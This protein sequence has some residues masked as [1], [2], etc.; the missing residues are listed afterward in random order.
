MSAGIPASPVRD[1]ELLPVVGPDMAN[2]VAGA[3]FEPA[4]MCTPEAARESRTASGVRAQAWRER[5]VPLLLGAAAL[6]TALALTGGIPVGAFYDDG[7]YVAL[8]EALATGEGYRHL[9]LPGEPAATHFPPGY[10]AFLALLWKVAPEFPANVALFRFANAVLGA[11]VAIGTYVFALRR[12]RLSSSVSAAAAAIGTISVPLLTLTVMLLSEPLFLAMVLPTLM[13]AEKAADEGDVRHAAAAGALAGL[14]TLVRSIGIG[15]FPVTVVLLAFRRRW[16]AAAACALGGLLV[17]LPWQRFVSAHNQA[18]PSIFGGQYGEYSAW[19]LE[20]VR[21][22]GLGF[23]TDVAM[24]N[25]TALREMFRVLFATQLP[26]PLAYVV[27]AAVLAVALLGA[28]ELARRAPVTA[29]FLLSYAAV[30]VVWPF[31]PT[32]FVWGIWPFL[33]LTL[34][35][36]AVALWRWRPPHVALRSTRAA[37]LAGGACAVVAHGVY[38]ARGFSRNLYQD[39][40]SAPAAEMRPILG[41]VSANTAPTDVLVTEQDIL[42]YLYTRR[43]TLPASEFTAAE[44]VTP[45]APA[46]DAEALR[47]IIAYPGVR[48]L[49]VGGGPTAKAAERLLHA[50]RPPIALVAVLPGGGAV[51][52]PVNP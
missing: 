14:V 18:V 46:A 5:R 49:I 37:L 45:R 39:A 52:R 1:D 42:V 34:A 43:Q 3:G 24:R 9:N 20:P 11:G 10:P 26:R 22:Q 8:A 44:Y 48:Y 12:L 13:L 32:R 33:W 40:F 29:W 27:L 15:I 35:A 17:V 30:V 36:G 21:A 7:I 25:A 16:A 19:A 38:S 2:P 50:G 23:V 31:H 28:R 4:G 6:L 51:F 47:R 41:W